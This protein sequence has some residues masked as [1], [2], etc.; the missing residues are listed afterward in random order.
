[1]SDERR[2]LEI[3]IFERQ[4]K[5]GAC[6]VEIVGPNDRRATGLFRS[7]LSEQEVSAAIDQLD[8]GRLDDESARR[9]GRALFDAL[10]RD[11]IRSVYDASGGSDDE[12]IGVRLIVDDL[13][14]GRIPWE[15]LFDPGIDAPLVSRRRFVRGFSTSSAARSI[16]AEPPLRILVAQSSPI[17]ADKLQSE[18]EI[19]DI[20]EAIRSVPTDRMIGEALDHASESSLVNRLREHANAE[21]SSPIHAIHWIGH[22]GI[23]PETGEPVL[24]FED[25]SQGMDLVDGARLRRMLG[26]FDIRVVFVN[27]CSS[28]AVPAITAPRDRG[29]SP[30]PPSGSAFVTTSGIAEELLRSGI[31]A[32]IG[33]QTRV[34]DD[35]ARRFARDFYQSIADGSEVDQ[36]ILDARRFIRNGPDGAATDIGI[37]VCYLRSGSTRLLNP[38][39]AELKGRQRPVLLDRANAWFDRWGTLGRIAKWASVGIASIF[40]GFAVVAGTNAIG[41]AL[42]PPPVL[43]GEF[44]VIVS[45]FDGMDSAG[46]PVE[47]ATAQGVSSNLYEE[48]KRELSGM[49]GLPRIEMFGPSDVGRI[50]GTSGDERARAAEKLAA[51]RNANL[52]IYG[53][54]GADGRS[55]QPT[56]Y[57]T[58]SLI[59]GAQ[60]LTGAF[61]LGSPVKSDADSAYVPIDLR[62]R[63]QERTTGITA[64]VAG[65]TWLALKQYPKSQADFQIAVDSAGWPN[66]DGKEVVYLFRGT[67]AAASGD[68][69]L[70]ESSYA[71]SVELNGEYGRAL[72][73]LGL[74][75][76]MRAGRCESGKANADRL[77]DAHDRFEAALQAADQPIL[78]NVPAK[79]HLGLGVVDVCLSQAGIEDAWLDA[80][81]ELQAVIDDFNGGNSDIQDIAAEAH[82]QLALAR[83][84]TV[85][86]PDPAAEFGAAAVE[87]AAAANLSKRPDRRA[88]F[89]DSLGWTY[90]QLGQT[91][92]AAAAFDRAIE[93]AQDPASLEKFRSDRASVGQASTSPGMPASVSP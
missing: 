52:V 37:P 70:A 61:R 93:F 15:L 23:H 54:L 69:D 59:Q 11:D 78:A 41:E 1:M 57:V 20:L 79:A 17:G 40:L 73:G 53:S 71:R 75:D 63:L 60:E 25:E 31:P 83:M 87:Y 4:R 72:Y 19:E 51:E 29:P 64:F 67:A 58:P 7:P 46:R 38:I 45:E 86:D 89:Y 74:V 12:L 47:N 62:R 21:P 65:L 27:A 82:G 49:S 9:D 8:R 77:H 80:E 76:V 56:F 66:S 39:P 92:D 43:A 30:G 48:L 18:P 3:R 13:E 85:E 14:A 42:K 44:N 90:K 36:A 22:G 50:G 24:L 5:N 91:A 16:T 84:P 28:A 32:V 6:R 10:I 81:Q 2:D 35:R 55:I 88:V 34:F 26:G 33:M 68:L